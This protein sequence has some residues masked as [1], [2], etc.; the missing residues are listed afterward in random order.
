MRPR[1]L[2]TCGLFGAAA[3]LLP[4]LFHLFQIGRV[5]MPM[6]LPLVALAFFAHPAAA[7]LTAFLVPLL[8]GFVTGMPPFMPPI[9]FVMSIELALM[10]ALIGA[11]GVVF[12]RLPAWVKLAVALA[13]GRVVNAALL[14]AAA[15]VFNLPAT[16]VAAI[17][18]LSGWPGLILMMLVIPALV[19]ITGRRET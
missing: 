15:R 2:A 12:P 4:V 17:S 16:F 1:D 19:R 10:A 3:L 6:Y 7:A 5:F 14:Y 8:S 11:L 13:V 9:A 18:L